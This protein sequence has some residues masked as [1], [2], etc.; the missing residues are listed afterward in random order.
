[1]AVF[2]KFLY[3]SDCRKQKL[4]FSHKKIK[5]PIGEMKSILKKIA[6]WQK[7]QNVQKL[8]C[9]TKNIEKPKGDPI[10]EYQIQ[11]RAQCRKLSNLGRG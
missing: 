5:K 6:Q 9:L 7:I 1:M 11:K 8:F 10:V 4:V 3:P 2:I